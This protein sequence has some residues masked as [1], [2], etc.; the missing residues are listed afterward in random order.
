MRTTPHSWT[1]SPESPQGKPVLT[2]VHGVESANDDTVHPAR[3]LLDEVVR[4]GARQMLA[5]ALQA[6]VAPPLRSMAVDADKR[7]VY[8]CHGTVA[9]PD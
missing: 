9:T 1:P 2:V 4:D 6:E 3:S 8:Q 7:P 5:A